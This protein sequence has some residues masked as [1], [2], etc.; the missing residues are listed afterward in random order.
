MYR[1]IF[2]DNPY[3]RNGT[4]IHEPENYG[5]KLLSGSVSLM[6]DSISSASFTVPFLNEGYGK[7]SIMKHFIEVVDKTTEESVFY[8]RISQIQT[9]LS[10][11]GQISNIISCE[12]ELAYLIDSIQ[13]F[14]ETNNQTVSS[15]LETLLHEHNSQV[16]PYK[17]FYLG[18]VTVN[19]GTDTIY[20]GISTGTTLDNIKDKLLSRLGG[21]L[22]CSKYEG[23]LYLNYLSNVGT[24]QEIPIRLGKNV[25]E[26]QRE[27][28]P[29]GLFTRVYP[30]GKEI[31]MPDDK[32]N[33][34]GNPRIDIA[35]VNGGKKYLDNLEL[36]NQFGVMGKA[37][38]FDDVSDKNIL[39]QKGQEE[40]MKQGL[41]TIGWTLSVVDLG[42]IDIAYDRIHLGDKY[43]I[44]I[45]LISANE[46]L[47]VLQK[48]INI[49][50]PH[51]SNLT[52]GKQQIKLSDMKKNDQLTS[53]RVDQLKKELNQKNYARIQE[54]TETKKEIENVS[55]HLNV[56][57]KD[58][59]NTKESLDQASKNIEEV[60][61][62]MDASIHEVNEEV[63]GV[64]S[65]VVENKQY[66]DDLQTT[67]TNKFTSVEIVLSSLQKEIDEL[68]N[69]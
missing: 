2:Y 23:K 8:G 55:E 26:A 44:D 48:Q 18:K 27:Y 9:S 46:T 37:V 39:K 35:C 20:R 58:F 21:F 51:K 47:Q 50:E 33:E 11:N 65:S 62:Q 61:N 6:L 54:I 42:L 30:F 68:M 19:P 22:T 34:F 49:A 52:F 32:Q 1:V 64:K 10:S 28:S 15:F 43:P 60:K 36:V 31:E 69:K 13:V 66:L 3:K 29:D 12:N 4:I 63:N 67:T 56:A 53:Q 57:I 7:F 16:E 5:G 14:Q 41:Q 24:T 17:R 45:P 25:L 40:L 38:V 59:E